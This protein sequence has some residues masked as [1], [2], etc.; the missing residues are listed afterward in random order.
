M[1]TSMNT[2]IS[3]SILLSRRVINDTEEH[4]RRVSNS[5]EQEEEI[6]IPNTEPQARIT[7]AET[8]EETL[9]LESLEIEDTGIKQVS[10]TQDQDS[11][12]LP[13]QNIG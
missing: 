1:G 9:Q 13:A 8:Q 5:G 2:A 3:P 6:M 4:Q 10:P 12:S 11:K 7:I